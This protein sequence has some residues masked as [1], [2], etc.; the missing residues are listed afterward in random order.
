MELL[1]FTICD[2]HEN[3]PVHSK[4]KNSVIDALN[5]LLDKW[6]KTSLSQLHFHEVV[7]FFH[8]RSLL[9]GCQW[10]KCICEK[11]HEKIL[12]NAIMILENYVSPTSVCTFCFQ[13]RTCVKCR[14]TKK[15]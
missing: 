3:V 1:F 8:E 12:M 13:P 7:H 4:I 9:A 15:N 6:G 10:S 5:N 14:V 11:D 2:N